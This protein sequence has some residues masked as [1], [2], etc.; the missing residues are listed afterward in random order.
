MD[1]TDNYHSKDPL[2]YGLRIP[3]DLD[4]YQNFDDIYLYV[5]NYIYNKCTEDKICYDADYSDYVIY[6]DLID[7]II[8][9]N[10]KDEESDSSGNKLKKDEDCGCP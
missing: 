8:E 9:G 7:Q 10:D 5:K 1:D 6:I 2:E 4:E 3:N